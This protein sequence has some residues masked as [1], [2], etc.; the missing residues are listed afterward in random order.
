MTTTIKLNVIGETNLLT[1]VSEEVLHEY[2]K[3][4]REVEWVLQ[5]IIYGIIALHCL[6][7]SPTILKESSFSSDSISTAT[8]VGGLHR[9]NGAIGMCKLLKIEDIML[10]S[11]GWS[12]CLLPDTQPNQHWRLPVAG[13]D[14][15]GYSS[16]NLT[17]WY[18]W[19]TKINWFN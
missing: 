3:R 5:T 18:C 17:G 4:R 11:R 8:N 9:G 14:M 10:Q 6:I 16:L 19:W 15:T 13:S 2:T 1:H 7:I 12:A